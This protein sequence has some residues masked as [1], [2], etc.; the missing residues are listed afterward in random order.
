MSN[1]ENLDHI[2]EAMCRF[3]TMSQRNN[4]VKEDITE[5][6][7]A[8]KERLRLLNGKGESTVLPM[9]PE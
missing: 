3:K 8:R 6:E 5:L 4:K 7:E 9:T 2:E 1:G